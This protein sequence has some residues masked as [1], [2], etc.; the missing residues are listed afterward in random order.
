M[1]TNKLETKSRKQED[2]RKNNRLVVVSY[3]QG[4]CEIILRI[5]Q[6]YHETPLHPE[7]TIGSPQRQED[8]GGNV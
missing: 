6:K 5:F 1:K 4:I 2:W 8:C 7:K 3:K